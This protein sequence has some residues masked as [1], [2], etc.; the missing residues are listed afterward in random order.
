MIKICITII[1][2]GNLAPSNTFWHFLFY[3]SRLFIY[4]YGC[5]KRKKNIKKLKRAK[6]NVILGV[7]CEHNVCSEHNVCG[8][9]NVCRE[10]I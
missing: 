8:E 6:K 9:H 3:S 10:H 5:Q 1:V 4:N 2:V 7:R